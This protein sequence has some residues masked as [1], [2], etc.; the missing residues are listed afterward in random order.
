MKAAILL[1]L[2]MQC[3]ASM[4]AQTLVQP[5]NLNASKWTEI[6][7]DADGVTHSP[8]SLVP[9]SNNEFGLTFTLPLVASFTPGVDNGSLHYLQIPFSKPLTG[10]AAVTFEVWVSV[11]G[12]P[13]VNY[14]L[15]P[16]NVCVSDA[17]ARAI[18]NTGDY[19]A[20]PYGRWYA[21]NIA[22]D[23]TEAV[24]REKRRY[25]VTVPLNADEWS[26]VDGEMGD[27]N[28]NAQVGFATAL[29][30]VELVG[31]VFGGGCFYGHGLSTTG[32]TVTFTIAN[33]GLILSSAASG[34]LTVTK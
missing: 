2:V 22:I 23:V 26:G 33:A 31:L 3:G 8:S 18:I 16:S 7:A 10:Y 28:A 19:S 15:E 13:I 29:H 12:K 30:N 17:H 4:A 27:S 1:S 14:D 24:K 25:V 32:G 9:L 11:T 34:D 20:Q 5:L 21:H 6:A